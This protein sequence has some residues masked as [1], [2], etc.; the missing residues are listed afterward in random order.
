M[1][2]G[3]VRLRQSDDYSEKRGATGALAPEV[4]LAVPNLQ[5]ACMSFGQFQALFWI[6]FASEEPY[7]G[8]VCPAVH[9]KTAT[10][11]IA[12]ETDN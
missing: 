12:G 10:A 4:H 2:K 5:A 3:R 8:W 7:M 6:P 11:D 9:S 1:F